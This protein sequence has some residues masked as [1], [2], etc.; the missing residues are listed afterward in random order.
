M[1]IIPAIA[2]AVCLLAPSAR[3]G[4]ETLRMGIQPGLSYLPYAVAAQGKLIEAAA[5]EAGLGDVSLIW[6]VFA[7]GNVMNDALISGDVD[8][9]ATGIS[10]FLVLWSK[11]HGK[12][13][14]ALY[15]Y[16]HMPLTLVSRNPAVKSIADFTDKDRIAIPAVK[17]SIQAMY[18]QMAA[19]K[20]WGPEKLY[21][22]DA[23]TVGRAHPDAMAAL[24]G[25]TEINAHF[26][27]PPFNYIELRDP[28]IHSVVDSE[29]LLGTP[30]SNG[31]TYTTEAFYR[32]NPKLIQ[33]VYAGMAEA[34]RIINEEPLR[35]AK[36]Y[37]AHGGEKLPPDGIV[38]MIRAPSTVWDLQPRGVMR[39]AQFMHRTSQISG[40]PA[41]LRELLFET[42]YPLGGN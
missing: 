40:A 15:S 9:A 17:V 30:I 42:A 16:G 20:M 37:L 3:A 12:M 13:V 29:T 27:I 28:R 32:A 8:I 5:K 39:I 36:L 11:T 35:A 10:G 6:R 24:L 14:R 7:V 4:S 38:M 25:N 22:L 33:A 2:L 1:R 23:L 19:E 41:E 21:A 26:A 18:L 34:M 31:I